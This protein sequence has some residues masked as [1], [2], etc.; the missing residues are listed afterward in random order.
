MQRAAQGCG[1][2]AI[3]A[4]RAGSCTAD[5]FDAEALHR[6]ADEF[7]VAMTSHHGGHGNIRTMHGS[8]HELAM[9]Q[10]DNTGVIRTQALK[11]AVG[12]CN[13]IG[14]AMDQP[15]K[16][17]QPPTGKTGSA[18]FVGRTICHRSYEPWP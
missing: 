4:A 2:A 16:P 11:D 10:P 17:S 12:L 14:R 8:H 7:S 18:H 3:F 6:R 9:P 1:A 15:N 5:E 13:D